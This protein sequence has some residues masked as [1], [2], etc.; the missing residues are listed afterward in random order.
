MSSTEQIADRFHT[1]LT[2][3]DAA[4]LTDLVADDVTFTGPLAQTSGSDETVKGLADMGAVT[5]SDDVD[6]RLADDE[7]AL[8]WATLKT[9]FSGP[10]PTATWLTVADGKITAIRTVFDAR[11]AEGH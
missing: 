6:V 5:T 10:T 9:R 3:G 7:N 2:S 8:I 1:A 4:A 11:G